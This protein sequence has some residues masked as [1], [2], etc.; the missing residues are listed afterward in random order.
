MGNKPSVSS[1]VSPTQS[2]EELFD[3]LSTLPPF[4]HCRQCGSKLLHVNVTFLSEGGKAWTLPLP[5]CPKCEP[6]KVSLEGAD[7]TSLRQKR[8]S[9]IQFNKALCNGPLLSKALPSATPSG[10]T[11]EQL[12]ERAIV[13]T[14]HAR[15]QGRI[16]DARHAI[17]DRAEEMLTLPPGAEQRALNNALKTLRLLEEVAAR[18]RP[19]AA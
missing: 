13:E 15:F 12:Y 14:D 1:T 8:N 4:I 7:I 11:W 2:V 10:A 16:T 9:M 18:E 3:S 5:S 19:A 6:L 17:L